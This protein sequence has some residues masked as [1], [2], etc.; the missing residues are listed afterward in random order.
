MHIHKNICNKVK[1]A[2][3]LKWK[4]WEKFEK[5]ELKGGN[6]GRKSVVILFQLKHIKRKSDKNKISM[7]L[8]KKS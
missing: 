4:V 6:W 5:E 3:S 1:E 2:I 8:I 7:F